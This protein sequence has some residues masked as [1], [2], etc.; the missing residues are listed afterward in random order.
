[1]ISTRRRGLCRL[2]WPCMSFAGNTVRRGLRRNGSSKLLSV[3]ATRQSSVPPIGASA[4]HCS[5]AA[6]L[7]RPSNTSNAFFDLPPAPG[8]RHC[9]IHY[10]SNDRADARAMLARALWMQGFAERALNEARASL[11]ELRGADHQLSLCR[12]LYYG[13]C[14]IASMIGDFATADREIARLIDVATS[15]NAPYWQTVGRFLKGKLLVER[16]SSRK[17]CRCCAMRSRH[18]TEPVGASRFRSSKALSRWRMPGLGS[19]TRRSMRWMRRWRPLARARTV[20]CGMSLSC[21]ASKAKSCCGKARISPP[22]RPKFV[23]TRP[24]R[25]PARRAPCSGSCGSRSA[26]PV[27]G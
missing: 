23:S 14:R 17:A 20:R 21:S 27:C 10:V 4:S 11:E 22:R 2:W 19:S 12:I 15:L 18:A 5:R 1:M 24:A 25:W 6:D 16:G 13:I 9:V 3:L 26:L 8:D 7:A